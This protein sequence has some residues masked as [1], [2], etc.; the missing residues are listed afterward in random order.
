[1]EA[2]WHNIVALFRALSP[3]IDHVN[4]QELLETVKRKYW[5][6]AMSHKVE[7][8]RRKL[9]LATWGDEASQLLDDLLGLMHS[10]H[11]D[12]TMTFRQL[13]EVVETSADCCGL[14][15]LL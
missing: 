2:G 9:G 6:V 5:S 8:F 7:T 13:A 4:H 15:Q 10:T 1:M 11:A 12:Y 14:L 3:L